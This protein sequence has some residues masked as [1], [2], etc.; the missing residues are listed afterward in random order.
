M[1][2][3]NLKIVRS[4]LELETPSLQFEVWKTINAIMAAGQQ[5]SGQINV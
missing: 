4:D 3:R 5:S 2:N 1:S